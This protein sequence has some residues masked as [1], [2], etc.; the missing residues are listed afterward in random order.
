MKGRVAVVGA[1]IVGLCCALEACRRGFEVTVIER[2]GR[3][4]DGTS[5]GNAGM[6]VP[7]HLTPLA[8]PGATAQ[9]LRWMADAGS[10][11]YVRP[12]AD[13]A[14]LA[15]GWRFW[16]ASTPARV[17]RA[18]PLLR[19]LHLASLEAY[20]ELERAWGG[21]FTVGRRGLLLLCASERGL[22][23]EAAA[24]RRA[25]DLGLATRLLDATGVAALQP[26]VEM[27]AVGG[28]HYVGDAH[29][30]PDAFMRALQA[31][32]ERLGATF[33]WRT[34]VAGADLGAAR[35]D[36][37]RI[38]RLRLVRTGYATSVPLGA[39][40]PAPPVREES[41]LEV[42]EVVLAAGIASAALAPA[43]GTAL[44]MQAGKGY[45]LT[46]PEPPQALTTP[47]ILS[48]ARVAV[49]P[50]GRPV[51]FGGTMEIDE[52]RPG[53]NPRRVRGIVAA[54][55]R[56][57]PAFREELFRHLPVWHGF[58]PMA[59]DTLPY[60]G[61]SRRTPNLVVATGHAMMG[62]SLAPVSGRIVAAVLAGEG[63]PFDLEP[64]APDR[65]AR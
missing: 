24:A 60:L 23:E 36:P 49:T 26:G 55:G 18:Q 5:Y 29:L 10:P 56:Y 44:P 22:E 14:L 17:A 21:A 4:R 35:G 47:T 20:G 48:E 63:V 19:D 45:S 42:D 64:L 62:V 11:L 58:R 37:R 3:E 65:F 1:G 34:E 30:E 43:F 51:R 40:E 27:A 6:L 31:E 28:V 9:A 53:P 12:R 57:F 41:T 54:A 50:F 25:S 33:R 52:P 16:R 59:P 39:D 8:T 15:W 61:R 32:V 13:P 46:L 2:E 7:S 38:A